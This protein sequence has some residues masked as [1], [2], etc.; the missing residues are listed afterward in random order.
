MDDKYIELL[1]KKCLNFTKSKSL[2]ISYDRIN[3][4]FVNK[5]IMKA[6]DMGVTDIACDEEDINITH[7]KL[8]ELSLADIENDPY[9]NKE[10]WNEYALKNANFLMLETEFPHIM[11]DIDSLKIEKAKNVNRKTREIFREKET[12]NEIPWCIAALPNE[13]WAQELFKDDPKAFQ[14]LENIIYKICMI[15]TPNPIESWNN[16]LK[17][18]QVIVNK[19]NS[20]EI[21]SLHYTNSLG[22]DLIV[23]MPKNHIWVSAANDKNGLVN[24]PSYEIFSSPNYLKTSGI[25]YNS[26]PLMYGGGIIDDFYIEFVDG[27][28]I[29]FDAQEGKELLQE[30]INSDEYSCY[31]GEIALVNNNSP[32]SNTNIVFKTTLFDENASCHLALGDGFRECLKNSEKM[33]KDELLSH[34]INQSKNHV[35]FMIGTPDL[36]IEAT[37]NKGK[38]K[39]FSNGNFCI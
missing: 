12:S 34:G 28:V 39:I 1:L 19:L 21:N 26:R 23:T 27:K 14:K 3:K 16:Y 5:L 32:I 29:N 35:D 7:S 6:K 15:D 36:E 22:T 17:E 13:I 4:D 20:M 37:T 31:L 11:D 8:K 10:K 24:M 25:V 2:F 33:S 30:I 9:F 18:A 38:I